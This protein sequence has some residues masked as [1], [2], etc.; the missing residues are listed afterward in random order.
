MLDDKVALLFRKLLGLG[1]VGHFQSVRFTQLDCGFDIE[2][3]FA[4]ART[5][6]VL[7]MV[8]VFVFF[9]VSAGSRSLAATSCR[10]R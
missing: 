6:S 5:V 9:Q 2:D 3:R 4:A 7:S 8:C 1:E 10:L